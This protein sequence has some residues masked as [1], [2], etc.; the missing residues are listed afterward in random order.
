MKHLALIV[1]RA[2]DW[3]RGVKLALA[4]RRAGIEV[5]L[6]VMDE[7]IAALAGDAAGRSALLDDD[8]EVVA[9]ATS[10]HE[11]GLGP[12]QVGVVLGSQDDHAAIVHRADRVVAFT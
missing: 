7:A 5:A 12:D 4:G 2:A 9:C 1:S 3:P 8:C 11:R 6:F 10:A